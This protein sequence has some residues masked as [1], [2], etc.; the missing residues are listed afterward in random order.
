[1]PLTTVVILVCRFPLPGLLISDKNSGALQLECNCTLIY[2]SSYELQGQSDK[3]V[4]NHG[5]GNIMR[6]STLSG[7]VL[8]H[9]HADLS[10]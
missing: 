3:L 8:D 5:N 2:S 1:M 6:T 4:I 7:F 10:G 9:D